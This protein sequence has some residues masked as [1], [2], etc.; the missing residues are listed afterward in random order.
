MM[1]KSR[2]EPLPPSPEA[3]EKLVAAVKS[4][5]EP[6]TAAALVKLVSPPD[7]VS[8]AVA[9]TLL[10]EAV[11]AG[12]LFPYSPKTAKGKPRYWD[13]NLADL[14]R[15]AMQATL[16]QIEVPF[17]LKELLKRLSSPV[18]F[19]ESDL[20][21]ILNAALE[22]QLLYPIPPATAKGGPRFWKHD[23]LEFG[24]RTILELVEKKGPQPES[25][26]LKAQK[27]FPAEQARE[28]VKRALA[29]RELRRHPICGKIKKELLGTRP[30]TPAPYLKEIGTQLIKVV[31][32]LK[33]ANVP[34]SSIR[35]DFLE[36]LEAAG[37]PGTGSANTHSPNTHSSAAS[38]ESAREF[39]SHPTIDLVALLKQMEPG[40]ARG[41][42]VGAGELRRAAGLGKQEFDRAVLDLARRQ[43]L[44]LHRHDYP[45]SLSPSALE[46]L[47]FDGVRTYYVGIALGTGG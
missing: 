36:L 15:S 2:K 35:R 16:P 18:K 43:H 37:L 41:A 7:R 24:R 12:T 6:M 5:A 44:V 1:A 31:S 23:L 3:C 46:E 33:E 32:V 22:A 19:T 9:V 40:A 39:L 17:T 30:P 21:P 38:P 13:R 42:L 11:L 8:E 47:V 28:V 27:G 45:T 14:A 34:L 10:D 26:L 20:L 25:A 29:N 4:A